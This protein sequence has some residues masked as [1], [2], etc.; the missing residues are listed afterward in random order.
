MNFCRVTPVYNWQ[1][2]QRQML[3]FD[4]EEFIYFLDTNAPRT[5]FITAAVP[6]PK[7]QGTPV[8]PRSTQNKTQRTLL[9][10]LPHKIQKMPRSRD[11]MIH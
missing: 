11:M 10:R 3:C 1:S 2:I 7:P 8:R 9:L 5:A 6:A 4:H